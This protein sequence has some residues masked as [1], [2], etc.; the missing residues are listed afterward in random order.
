MDQ[1]PGAL[2]YLAAMDAAQKP[3]ASS[4]WAGVYPAN[5]EEP[6]LQWAGTVVERGFFPH[7]CR[8]PCQLVCPQGARFN[9]GNYYSRTLITIAY[10]NRRDTE[11]YV[12]WCGRTAGATPPPTR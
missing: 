10:L 11:P 5:S 4:Y 7:E 2:P 9:R 8:V 3:D 6:R 1:T 12:R